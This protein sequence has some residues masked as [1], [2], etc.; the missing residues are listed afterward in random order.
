M[1][2]KTSAAS[3]RTE[4]EDMEQTIDLLRYQVNL[5][6][7]MLCRLSSDLDIDF[8]QLL[9]DAEDEMRKPDLRLV[10]R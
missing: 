4:R 9:L 5:L 8:D 6:G 7:H 1:A 10:K 2:T 3:V